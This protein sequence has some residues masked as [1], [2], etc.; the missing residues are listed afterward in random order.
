M[1]KVIAA[2]EKPQSCLK[3]QIIIVSPSPNPCLFALHVFNSFLYFPIPFDPP[4]R[5]PSLLYVIDWKNGHSC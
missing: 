4:Y 2:K 5:H 3:I 1:P